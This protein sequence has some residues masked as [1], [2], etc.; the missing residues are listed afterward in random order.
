MYGES[1]QSNR[2]LDEFGVLSLN[3]CNLDRA[4]LLGNGDAP[5]TIGLG[6]PTQ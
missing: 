4:K 6:I 2:A 3:H 5:S 1:H